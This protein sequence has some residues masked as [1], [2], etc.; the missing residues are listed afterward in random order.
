MPGGSAPPLAPARRAL[1]LTGSS[2][3][4]ALAGALDLLGMRV[5]QPPMPPDPS[6]PQVHGESE[7]LVQFHERL[8]R[9][10]NVSVRDAR[11]QAWFETGRF[12]TTD[13]ARKRARAWL[14][15]QFGP[16]ADE[17]VLED[18]RLV[19]FLGLWRQAALSSD[20]VAS[21]VVMIH[22]PA[23]EIAGK[24]PRQD[25]NVS[26]ASR[27]ASWLNLMLHSERATR[28]QPRA[29][30]RYYDL[31]DD[32][33]IPIHRLGEELGLQAVLT[34]TARDVRLVHDLIDSRPRAVRADRT[35]LDLPKPLRSLLEETWFHLDQ[36]ADGDDTAAR[37]GALD[38]LRA[39]YVGMYAEAES[40]TEATTAA[41]RRQ[42]RIEQHKSEGAVE[43]VSTKSD[44]RAAVRLP[45][46][47]FGLHGRRRRS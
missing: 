36:L 30:I 32:W 45:R 5:P 38:E 4:S 11:P 8:L 20:V 37:Y 3:T 10:A 35:E 22:P 34:S 25:E 43:H 9:K 29:F 16:D 26:Q 27:A 33:T 28:G 1:F 12:A 2:G 40:I 7:W 47:R 21:Y 13:P 17:V 39:H 23:E 31:V 24:G 14:D 42:A 46:G 18:P 41:A 19:W 15:A 6:S 44:G